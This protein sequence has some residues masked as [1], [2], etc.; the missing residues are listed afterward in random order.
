MIT[1]RQIHLLDHKW[2]L[3]STEGTFIFIIPL[4]ISAT[5]M[6][7]KFV[8]AKFCSSLVWI[9][10]HAIEI[11][12][13]LR[14]R[15]TFIFCNLSHKCLIA[16]IP[17]EIHNHVGFFI[18]QIKIIFGEFLRCHHAIGCINIQQN[19]AEEVSGK[20]L[21]LKASNWVHQFCFI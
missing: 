10:T 18:F 16:L 2:R 8:K 15:C 11:S 6:D 17:N 13:Q 9:I 12:R 20:A 5:I 4:N 1:L 21:T 14:L 7:I 3:C 19:S